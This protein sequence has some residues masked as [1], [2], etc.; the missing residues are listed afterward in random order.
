MT[1]FEQYVAAFNARKK[2]RNFRLIK[3]F[4]IRLSEDGELITLH[5]VDYNWTRDPSGKAKGYRSARLQHFATIDK[6]DVFRVVAMRETGY[7][8]R[9]IGYV[10]G[11]YVGLSQLRTLTHRLRIRDH[12][13]NH[14]PVTNE[15]VVQL[16]YHGKA[17]VISHSPDTKLVTDRKA[18]KPVY[19]FVNKAVKLA[20]LLKRM[21]SMEP[22]PNGTALIE[23]LQSTSDKSL[24]DENLAA[25]AE[26]AYKQARWSASAPYSV[27]DR[28]TGG[29]T[30]L[31]E[32]QRE[33][34]YHRKALAGAKRLLTQELKK[35]HGGIFTAP[36]NQPKEQ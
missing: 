9:V 21:G 11:L 17:K 35:L 1:H 13:H 36:I 20:G 31:T 25:M 33:A 27:Y 15:L 26:A 30:R 16:N 32:E 18:S 22:S 2:D 34:I 5:E 7:M 6:N 12:N 28:N 29:F 23:L 3:N 14:Y 19:E 10:T 24:T 8:Q 4:G